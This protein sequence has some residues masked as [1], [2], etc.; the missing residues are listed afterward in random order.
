MTVGQ[1]SIIIRKCSFDSSLRI[2]WNR[3]GLAN[4][5]EFYTLCRVIFVGW[6]PLM[7]PVSILSLLLQLYSLQAY[8]CVLVSTWLIAAWWFPTRQSKTSS[9]EILG[10]NRFLIWFNCTT[11]TILVIIKML[12]WLLEWYMDYGMRGRDRN[13]KSTI[14]ILRWAL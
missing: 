12:G 13:R 7:S 2:D 10:N 3:C 5:F 9:S 6:M 1:R 11:N 4:R 8:Q 14:E